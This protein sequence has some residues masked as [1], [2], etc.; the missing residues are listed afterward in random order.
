M[1]RIPFE[2]TRPDGRDIKCRAWAPS[3]RMCENVGKTCGSH[4]DRRPASE[5]PLTSRQNGRRHRFNVDL[6][7][8]PAYFLSDLLQDLVRSYEGVAM[9]WR[10]LRRGV[11][12][13]L[14]VAAASTLAFAQGSFFSS[15]S[16][17]VADSSGAVIPG[18][19]VKIRNN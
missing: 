14:I 2:S 7:R 18:A 12:A 1:L 8:L 15:L 3:S 13:L 6:S 11:L 5:T 19:D 17:T 16:G 4:H 9:G 10:F